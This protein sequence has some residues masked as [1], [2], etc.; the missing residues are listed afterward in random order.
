MN[1]AGEPDDHHLH[2]DG[3]DPID[4]VTMMMMLLVNMLMTMVIL[5][6]MLTIMVMMILLVN[7]FMTMVMILLVN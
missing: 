3:D 6:N 7:L 1:R 4:V 5:V 2:P